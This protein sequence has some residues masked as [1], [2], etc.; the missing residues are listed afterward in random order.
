MVKNIIKFI[1]VFLSA[2]I[3]ITGCTKDEIKSVYTG[4][5]VPALTSSAATLKIK[6]A[7]SLNNVITFNWT[8]PSYQISSGSTYDITYTLDIDTSGKGFANAKKTILTNVLTTTMTGKAFN[9]VLS[10]L[11]MTDTTKTYTINARLHS[12]LYLAS[13]EL[14]SNVIS[15]A[16]TPY[17]TEPVALYPVPNNL[18]LVG[19]ATAGGWN[20]PVPTPTQQFTKL[21]KFSFGG[22]FQL[23]GGKHYL[24]LPTNGDWGHKYAVANQNAAGAADGAS[25]TVDAGQDIPAPAT[26]GLYKIVVSYLTGKYTVTAATA[27]IDIPPTNLFLVGDAT[28]GGWNNPVPVPSQQFTMVSSGAFEI[29]APLIGGKAYLLLPKN[30]D[31]GHKYAVK[32]GTIPSG[33]VGGPFIADSGDNIPGPDV[34]G[35]YKIQVEFITKT[36]KVTKQ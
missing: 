14:I 27:A 2:V 12:S 17:S 26:D 19:D 5:S 21:D 13:T 10:D 3:I 36:Y 22:V 6:A 20:N 28:A 15:M 31:W 11:G 25:F 9:K 33:K 23:V 32:D 30:G 1:A 24:F 16:V 4:G 35:T 18:F 8:N 29:T 34:S 7:D